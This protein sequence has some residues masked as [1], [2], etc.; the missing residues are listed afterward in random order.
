MSSEMNSTSAVEP[1]SAHIRT[2]FRTRDVVNQA[3]AAIPTLGLQKAA[4]FLSAMN[5]PPEV[6]I[7]A[8]VYPVKRKH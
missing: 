1:A 4:E 3:I 6:A 2:D 7:R 8:L 5:V